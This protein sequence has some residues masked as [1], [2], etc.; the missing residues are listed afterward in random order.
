VLWGSL[1][2][3]RVI[4]L[5]VRWGGKIVHFGAYALMGGLGAWGFPQKRPRRFILAAI[6][7]VGALVEVLQL[8]VPGRRGALDDAL[9]DAAGVAFGAWL[10]AKHSRGPLD[11][12]PGH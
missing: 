1:T 5:H 4:D 7:V 12:G 10:A 11:G 3:E 8:G 2:P 6:M 9:C